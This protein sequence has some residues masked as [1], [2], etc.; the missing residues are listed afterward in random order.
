MAKYLLWYWY[1]I[2]GNYVRQYSMGVHV[3]QYSMGVHAYI[4][5][6]NARIGRN[7]RNGQAD[8]LILHPPS[9]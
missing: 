2:L 5:S 3:R 6:F 4:H 8:P 7:L 1:I 9:N